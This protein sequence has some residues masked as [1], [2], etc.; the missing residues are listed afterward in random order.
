MG[1]LAGKIFS[2]QSP[3][4]YRNEFHD[5]KR[6]GR[7]A[8][9]VDQLDNVAILQTTKNWHFILDRVLLTSNF[10]LVNHLQRKVQLPRPAHVQT[11]IVTVA[12]E[13]GD[14]SIALVAC[15][16]NWKDTAPVSLYVWPNISAAY[17]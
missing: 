9:L 5:E 11:L 4:V 2:V 14:Q 3:A 1:V 17:F 10:D 7:C 6:G 13:S 15:G 16:D 8:K 12:G